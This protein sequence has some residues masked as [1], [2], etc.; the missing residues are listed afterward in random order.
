MRRTERD[1]ATRRH[2][3]AAAVTDP[4]T[5]EAGSRK[6]G[7]P[8]RR[9]SALIESDPGQD[10]GRLSRFTLDTDDDVVKA[11]QES[12]DSAASLN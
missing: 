11:Y 8:T 10:D 6:R 3:I 2:R 12:A 4:D 9:E 7:Q 1:V 5:R